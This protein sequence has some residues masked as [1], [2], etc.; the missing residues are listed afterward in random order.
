MLVFYFQISQN[1][2]NVPL[3]KVI[4]NVPQQ[5]QN[6]NFE[7]SLKIKWIFCYLLKFHILYGLKLNQ[8]MSLNRIYNES[9]NPIS[10]CR[11]FILKLKF[12][13]QVAKECFF[14]SIQVIFP[15]LQT[16][17]CYNTETICSVPCI[18]TTKQE[19][20][21]FVFLSHTKISV[22]AP[23]TEAPLATILLVHNSNMLP[24]SKSIE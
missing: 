3:P 6:S 23:R 14:F 17:T 16:E 1:L 15:I 11:T 13:W 9:Q 22:V 5:K 18:F 20:F 21:F 24:T 7:F 19:F 12:S 10:H 8:K 4:L 2:V